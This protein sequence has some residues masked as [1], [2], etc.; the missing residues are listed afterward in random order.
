MVYEQYLMARA[1]RQWESQGCLDV[2]LFF[3]M[4][5]AGID[6]DQAERDFYAR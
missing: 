5:N 1:E 2:D 3:E 4:M 6:V